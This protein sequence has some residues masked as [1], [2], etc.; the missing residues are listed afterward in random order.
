M[1]KIFHEKIGWS[2]YLYLILLTFIV[3]WSMWGKY[4]VVII[5]AM[6]LLVVTIEKIIHT[7]YTVTTDG[8]LIVSHGRFC[9]K[10]EIEIRNINSVEKCHSMNFRN[11][12][13][14]EWILI[15]Y[16]DNK[17]LSVMP[18]KEQEFINLI[19]HSKAKSGDV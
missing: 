6:L 19:K 9:K 17:Y 2:Q 8:R 18:I 3:L 12:H 14:A 16:S 15:R 13:F 1:N 5:I 11:F 10:K 7:T 4:I